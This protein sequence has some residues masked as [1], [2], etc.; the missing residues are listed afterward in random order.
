M[1]HPLIQVWVPAS[2]LFV[3]IAFSR[4]EASTLAADSSRGARLLETLT[5]LQCHRINGK[6][7]TG[8]SDFGWRIAWNFT[9]GSV[10]AAMWNHAPVMW[11]DHARAEHPATGSGRSGCSR[12][13]R[14]FLL[15]SI[16]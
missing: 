14:L 6:C 4:L 2:L 9:P 5:C 3:N 16:L 8:A 13:V 7:G 11:G 10:A 15:R 12:S 1:K